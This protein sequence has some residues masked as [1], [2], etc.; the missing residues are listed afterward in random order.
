MMRPSSFILWDEGGAG[1]VD[2][3]QILAATAADGVSD[4]GGDD[5]AYVV[6]RWPLDF[7]RHWNGTS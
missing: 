5:D 7:V 2:H 4:A 1:A 6:G 3:D